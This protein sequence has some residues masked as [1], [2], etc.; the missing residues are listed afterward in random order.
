MTFIARLDNALARFESVLMIGMFT[1]AFFLGVMQVVLR[2]VF[3]AGFHWNE[4]IFV[5]FTLTAVLVGGSRA[6]RDGIHARV[7]VV[8]DLLPEKSVHILNLFALF[9]SLL[10]CGL[11]VYCGFLYTKFVHSMGLIGM[12]TQ[13][14]ESIAFSI[15]PFTMFLFSIRYV[16]KMIEWRTDPGA[17]SRMT[18]I[19][20]SEATDGRRPE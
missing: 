16:I 6:V 7:E 9:S 11:Y 13:I 4:A 18:E 3:N 12:E 14:P 2:Y 17:Y 1:I 10:L 15:V 20:H 8:T 5:L 19:E